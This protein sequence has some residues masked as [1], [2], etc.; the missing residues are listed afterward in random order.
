MMLFDMQVPRTHMDLLLK[1]VPQRDR[2]VAVIT[3]ANGEEDA[4]MPINPESKLFAKF[5]QKEVNLMPVEV[6]LDTIGLNDDEKK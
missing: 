2:T 3:T 6:I 4:V 5:L 1:Q